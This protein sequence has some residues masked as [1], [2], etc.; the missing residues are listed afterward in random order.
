MDDSTHEELLKRFISLNLDKKFLDTT[1]LTF[2]ERIVLLSVQI[3]STCSKVPRS[4][5]VNQTLSEI[6]PDGRVR[7]ADPDLNP[8]YPKIMYLNNQM[9]KFGEDYTV[10]MVVTFKKNQPRPGTSAS[11]YSST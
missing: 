9:L 5:F 11:D 6:F 2:E 4:R 3:C 8:Y 7:I 10:D 1:S